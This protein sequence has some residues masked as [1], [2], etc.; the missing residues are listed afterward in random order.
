MEFIQKR[1]RTSF[2]IPGSVFSIAVML[3]AL[4]FYANLFE[5][6]LLNTHDAVIQCSPTFPRMAAPL[7]VPAQGSTMYDEQIGCTFTQDFTSLG[8]NVIAVA[9]EGADNI[10]PAYLVNGLSDAGYWYQV[11]LSYNWSA[12][13]GFMLNYEVWDPS[14][15]SIFPV[16]GGG[17]EFFSDTINQGDIILLSLSFSTGTGV[18]MQ[19]YD[20]NTSANA[21]VTYR[22]FGATTFTGDTS[23]SSNSQ[24]YFT[25]LMT[26]WY[27][28][29]PYYGDE[30]KVSYSVNG[31]NTISSAWLWVN[32]FG[33]T[34][35]TNTFSSLFSDG[36]SS[37]VSLTNSDLFHSFSSHGANEAISTTQFI[38]GSMEPPVVLTLNYTISSTG[39]PPP[40]VFAFSNGGVQK[41]ITLTR[42]TQSIS[43]DSGSSWSIT[44][45]LSSLPSERW[46]TAQATNGVANSSQTIN[47]VFYH[48]YLLTFNFQ[49][50]G[51]GSGYSAPIVTYQQFGSWETTVIGIQNWTDAVQYTYP[52][53]LTGS[54]EGERWFATQTSGVISSSDNI[55][56]V[57]YHQYLLNVSYS[58]TGGGNPEVP[59][60]TSAAFGSPV[61]QTL[62]T[63]SQGLWVDNSASYS[64]TNPLAGSTAAERWQTDI[65]TEGNVT[66]STVIAPV[67]GHQY[68]V[69]VN[70]EPAV[71]GSTSTGS[72]WYDTG[73]SSHSTASA[74]PGWQFEDW[75]GIG[76]GSYSGNDTS[77]MATVNAPIFETA[78]FFPGLTLNASNNV[79][80][81]YTHGATSGSVEPG[82][83]GTIFAPAG[84]TIQLTA[85]PK[86]LLYSFSGW[87]GSY[88]SSESNISAN[89][90]T[91]QS[92]T[93]NSK[94]NVV[95][96]GSLA[97][98]II[99]V[100]IGLAFLI[101]RTKRKSSKV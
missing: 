28:D 58:L 52:A 17:V 72:G 12:N 27:H 89:L 79:S 94:L 76:Q 91:P 46:Q 98:I 62:S 10:G 48:Q 42:S 64:L 40:P 67:Y 8:Y 59:T 31:T 87:T 2:I 38:T 1:S 11:G 9:Q 90:D 93:A 96:I 100:I 78:N 63:N 95:T 77:T 6:Q 25:G 101:L 36:T 49:V 16:A 88:T 18:I 23:S 82:K 19:G 3:L 85:K 99:V 80:I 37:P 60:F 97:A 21:E 75:N 14:G 61:S 43:V 66:F 83:S 35:S 73:T 41:S 7:M 20:R 56:A 68:Y 4:L 24:G 15:K 92:V 86:S 13:A 57:Y 84:T 70:A 74:E 44:S 81:L 39:A 71:G 55:V 47:F 33:Y 26:E 54:S 65:V 45:Q 22:A 30:Q 32:E 29:S 34:Q 51:G 69:T 53:S 5:N 50:V